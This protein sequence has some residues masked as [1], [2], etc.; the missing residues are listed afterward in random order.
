MENIKW[1][2]NE[3]NNPDDDWGP[4]GIWHEEMTRKEFDMLVRNAYMRGITRMLIELEELYQQTGNNSKFGYL[5]KEHETMMGRMI[6][7]E[8]EIGREQVRD[9]IISLIHKYSDCARKVK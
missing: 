3:E 1:K 7:E 6:R 5:G 4:L 2:E 9:E 8:H